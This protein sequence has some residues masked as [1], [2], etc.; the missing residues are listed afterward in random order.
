MMALEKATMH[1]VS[2]DLALKSRCCS[3]AYSDLIFE[4]NKVYHLRTS[5]IGVLYRLK[6]L[7]LFQKAFFRSFGHFVFGIRDLRQRADFETL[8]F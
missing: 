7:P 3:G 6:C 5:L 2:S 8:R 4:K 1:I